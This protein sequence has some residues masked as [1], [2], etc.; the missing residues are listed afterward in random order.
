[1]EFIDSLDILEDVIDA[2]PEALLQAV[3]TINDMDETMYYMVFKE[4]ENINSKQ[5]H[6]YH[7]EPYKEIQ[8]GK[9]QLQSSKLNNLL[10][11]EKGQVHLV[12][13]GQY[14]T[15]TLNLDTAGQTFTRMK[16]SFIS[17]KTR[18]MNENKGKLKE[19]VT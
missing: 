1:M 8:I 11:D 7:V 5:G 10:I 14:K 19:G 17:K 2:Y 13:Y 15:S 6:Q 16:T 12:T 3:F 18:T 9:L 4:H